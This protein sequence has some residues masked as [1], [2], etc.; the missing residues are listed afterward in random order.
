MPSG[1]VEQQ[2]GVAAE[3]DHG[4]NLDQVQAHRLWVAD[5]TYVPTAA[6]FLF[7]AVVL[8]VWSRRIVGWAMA[9]DQRTRLVLDALDMAATTRK[10]ADVVRHSNR[11]ANTRRWPSP[12]DAEKRALRPSTGLVGDA[13]DN[14]MAEAFFATLECE[15]LDRR[16]FGSQVEARMAVFAFIEGFYNPVRRHSALSY[17]S[18]IEYEA[19]AMV[20]SD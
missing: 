3:A 8:E 12:W 20:M 18:P 19:R 17:L 14:L 10:P 15:L 6:G 4:G 7:L 13:Y 16:S 9:T 2:R 1:L 11:A 5:I